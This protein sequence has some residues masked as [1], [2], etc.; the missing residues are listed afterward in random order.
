M[1][2]SSCTIN[3]HVMLKTPKDYVFDTP[4]EKP[5][6]EY[7]ISKNDFIVLRLYSND[8]FQIIDLTSKGNTNS[9]SFNP[10]NTIK[11]RVEEDSTCKLPIIGSIVLAGKT[12]REAEAYLE[13]RYGEF[14]VD[15]YAQLQITNKRVLVFPG[16]GNSAQVIYFK[17]NNT[18]L[19]EAIALAGGISRDGKA[20][21]IKIVRKTP[22][23][24]EIYHIDLSTI[25]G[26]KYANMVLQGNDIIYVQP[27]PNIAREVL[28]DITPIL[29]LLSS[30]LLVWLTFSR[31]K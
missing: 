17:N 13:E 29:S 4:P 20:K 22:E 18:T 27:V 10:S 5:Q 8:G 7:V 1:G 31:I 12:I 28:S 14:Y 21:D 24:Q 6:T 26:L 9:N 16:T 11:Y 23:K 19:L 30:T 3:S 15:P 25:D 2:L